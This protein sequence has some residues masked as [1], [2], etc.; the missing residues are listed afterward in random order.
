MQYCYA[1]AERNVFHA[2]LHLVFTAILSGKYN[3]PFCFQMRKVSPTEVRNLY[4]VIQLTSGTARSGHR[5]YDPRSLAF[6]RHTI[7]R[8][9]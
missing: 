3:S 6:I 8:A 4:N 5:Q 2:S 7:Q 1:T 9:M